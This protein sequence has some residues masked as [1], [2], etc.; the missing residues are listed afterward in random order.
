LSVSLV[1]RHRTRNGVAKTTAMRAI[2]GVAS[3]DGGDVR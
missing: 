3:L 1:R 2:V